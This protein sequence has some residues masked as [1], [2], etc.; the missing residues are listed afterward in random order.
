[1]APWCAENAL[2]VDQE[3]RWVVSRDQGIEGF[4]TS[5]K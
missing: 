1:V 5:P 3:G 2:S 4:C